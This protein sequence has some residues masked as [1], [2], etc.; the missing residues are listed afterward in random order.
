MYKKLRQPTMRR[1]IR[2]LDT[3]YA[4]SKERIADLR[5]VVELGEKA[6]TIKNFVDAW[7]DD[8]EEKVLADLA[9]PGS[10]AEQIKLHYQAALSFS[11]KIADTIATGKQ[12]EETLRKLTRNR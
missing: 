9:K 1:P 6:A 2:S 11:E 3:N 12:K 7:L 5:E 8:T 10:N 4:V